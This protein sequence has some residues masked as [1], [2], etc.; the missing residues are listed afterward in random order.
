LEQGT[1]TWGTNFTG[2]AIWNESGVMNI[3]GWNNNVKQ[4]WGG[5]D[6]E[7]H[8]GGGDVVLDESGIRL[9]G[10]AGGL[11]WYYLTTLVGKI[12]MGF[13]PGQPERTFL[14]LQHNRDIQFNAGY[15]PDNQA[16]AMGFNVLG[17]SIGPIDSASM[18]LYNG[19]LDVDGGVQAT[20]LIATSSGAHIGGTSDPGTNN[21]VVEGTIKDGSGIAYLK[22]NAKAADSDKLDGLDSTDFGRPVFLTTPLTSTA[23]D[24]DSFSTTAKTKIDLSVVF[25]VPAGAKGIFVRLVARDSGSSAG[26]CQLSL[27][28][29]ATADSVAVQA[30]LQGVPNDVYVPVNGVV[31]CDENGDV[32]YQIVA[33]GTGTLDAIIEIWGY[34]L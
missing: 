1:G 32:Y 9:S 14:K 28:P 3:G 20:G 15:Q 11:W 21:L 16:G 25:G 17:S 26:Y 23:W 30:Y 8:A 2:S 18:T 34:W 6:G 12:Y 22:S 24:G 27:S 19:K 13:D 31:P 29:N 10:L 7:L 4:W 33:S 5:S